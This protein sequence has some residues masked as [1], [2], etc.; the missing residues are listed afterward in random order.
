MLLMTTAKL[1]HSLPLCF[2]WAQVGPSTFFSAKQFEVFDVE[3]VAIKSCT[4]NTSG[5]FSTVEC[6]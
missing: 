6:K 3:L 2:S 5:M 4:R 1:T